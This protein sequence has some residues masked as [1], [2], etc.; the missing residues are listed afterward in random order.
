MGENEGSRGLDGCC[1]AHR[2]RVAWLTAQGRAT[3]VLLVGATRLAVVNSA[4]T[5]GQSLGGSFGWH[6]LTLV[7]LAWALA[8]IELADARAGTCD[9]SRI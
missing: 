1:G 3:E 7:R 2:A 6:P 9:L 5:V 8:D 4:R